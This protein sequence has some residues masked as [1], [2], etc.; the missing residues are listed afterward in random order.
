MRYEWGCHLRGLHSVLIIMSK[1]PYV[2]ASDVGEAGE[3]QSQRRKSRW[4]LWLG[5]LMVLISGLVFYILLSQF[6]MAT[7]Q[8]GRTPASGSDPAAV[9]GQVSSILSYFAITMFFGTVGLVVLV[10]GWFRS[11]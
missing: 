4:L 10:L 11:R 3:V 5:L 9:A 7:S 1:N 8:G 6:F 2:S